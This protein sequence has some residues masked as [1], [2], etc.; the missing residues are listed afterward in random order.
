MILR[1]R[2]QQAP[3]EPEVA[4]DLH[5][6]HDGEPVQAGQELHALGRHARPAQARPGAR[7]ESARAAP[8]PR[9]RRGRRPTPRPRGG[10]SWRV[11]MGPSAT[12]LRSA[13]GTRSGGPPARGRAGDATCGIPLRALIQLFFRLR[14]TRISDMRSRSAPGWPAPRRVRRGHPVRSPRGSLRPVWRHGSSR[15]PGAGARCRLPAAGYAPRSPSGPWPRA[16]DCAASCSS[17]S[18][19]RRRR[20][21]PVPAARFSEM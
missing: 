12:L 16:R 17:S 21:S 1:T 13:P 5:E 20:N 3:K 8:A 14:R 7:R 2:A 6:A 10:G 15:A 19:R 9:R 4:H 11:P 18:R